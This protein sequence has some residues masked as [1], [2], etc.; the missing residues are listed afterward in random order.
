MP[1]AHLPFVHRLGRKQ[2]EAVELYDDWLRGAV[3]E[4]EDYV[5]DNSDEEDYGLDDEEEPTGKASRVMWMLIRAAPDRDV[6]DDGYDSRVDI[7]VREPVSTQLG[8]FTALGWKSSPP[9]ATTV[10]RSLIEAAE[11][12]LFLDRNPARGADRGDTTCFTAAEYYNYNPDDDARA[13]ATGPQRGNAAHRSQPRGHANTAAGGAPSGRRPHTQPGTPH[14]AHL[15]DDEDFPVF[16]DDEID[17]IDEVGD[18]DGE[19]DE[20]ADDGAH[21]GEGA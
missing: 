18:L 8:K 7:N 10:A 4:D 21:A 2:W 6:L 1:D 14:A 3:L 11:S 5:P 12:E 20:W 13:C 17:E 15:L 16:V 19:D 9:S